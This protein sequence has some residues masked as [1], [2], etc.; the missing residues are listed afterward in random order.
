MNTEHL[1]T[2]GQAI[3]G[4]GRNDCLSGLVVNDIKSEINEDQY[5]IFDDK[6]NLL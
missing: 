6:K 4:E 2:G 3:L 5:L 1:R